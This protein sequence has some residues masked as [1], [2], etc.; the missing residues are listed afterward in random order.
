MSLL[1]DTPT[2]FFARTPEKSQSTDPTI[3]DV[4][5]VLESTTTMMEHF[6]ME[7][8]IQKLANVNLQNQI[9]IMREELKTNQEDFIDFKKH[10]QVKC[11]PDQDTTNLFKW[12]INELETENKR[13]KEELESQKSIIK[14]LNTQKNESN[15]DYNNNWRKIEKKSTLN[16]R[17]PHTHQKTKEAYNIQTYN[18]YSCLEDTTVQEQ[19]TMNDNEAEGDVEPQIR[20]NRKPSAPRKLKTPENDTRKDA[21]EYSEGFS[22]GNDLYQ[23]NERAS[24]HKKVVPGHR[25][26]ASV[27][28]YGK[29]VCIVGDSHLKRLKKKVFNTSINHA[30]TYISCFSGANSKR[31]EYYVSP[32]LDEDK[33]D[34]VVIHVGSN[35]VNHENFDRINVTEISERIINIGKQCLY[36]GVKEVLISS[37]FPKKQIKLTSII[38]EINDIL[39][40]QCRENNFHFICNDNISRDY[41]WKDGVHLNDEGTSIFESNIVNFLNNF[42]FSESI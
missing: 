18:K 29:K 42:I 40:E 24:N 38:R 25:S 26:Y 31:L 36:Y 14:I 17:Y 33:P 27:T 11:H 19:N 28:R 30:K 6:K 12:R 22:R 34:V 23:N 16:C 41:L 1:M 37:I 20:R 35:D 8:E 5:E 39:K 4:C 10:V 9:K 15:Y 7:L 13:L 21:L 3:R 2:P 32:T